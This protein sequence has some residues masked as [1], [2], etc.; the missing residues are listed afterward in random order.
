MSAATMSARASIGAERRRDAHRLCATLA[1]LMAE[2]IRTGDESAVQRYR[3]DLERVERVARDAPK[4]L[5]EWKNS[6]NGQE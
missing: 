1:D 4:S 2:A 5:S 6:E 3:Q